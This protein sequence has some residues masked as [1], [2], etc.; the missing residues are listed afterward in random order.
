MSIGIYCYTNKTNSKK[1]IGQSV[2]LEDRHK[3]HLSR[4]FSPLNEEYNSVIHKAFR[5]YG[6][7]N[8]SYEIIE[9]CMIE[10]LNDKEKYYISLY[11]SFFNGYNMTLG[12]DHHPNLEKDIIKNITN[13]LLENI[14]SIE[15]ISKKYNISDRSIRAINTGETW[16]RNIAYPINPELVFY[17]HNTKYYCISCGKEI[18][19]KGK[20]G[21]CME[22]YYEESRS[23]R[24][25]PLDLA[26]MIC[27]LGFV[28]VGKKY[29]VDGNSIKKWCKVYGI[30]HLKQELKEW[31]QKQL[32]SMEN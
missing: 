30:P 27:E 10:E 4:A 6:L 7:D 11:D 8:F 16:K 2:D 18:K 15:E 9:E 13:D 23:D 12:G 31:Y 17:Q 5:K 26:K 3:K 20:T 19:G 29:N 25:K 28:G 32:S 22:C 1:Y 24:P 14:L 21:L